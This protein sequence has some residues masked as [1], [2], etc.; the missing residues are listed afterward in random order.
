MCSAVQLQA[1]FHILKNN[2]G[3]KEK[4][5][6]FGKKVNYK[7]RLSCISLLGALLFSCLQLLPAEVWNGPK[8]GAGQPF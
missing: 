7:G 3:Q 6:N 8:T 1:Y 2:Y 5:P 4:H